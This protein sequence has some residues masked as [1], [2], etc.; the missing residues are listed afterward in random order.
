MM[1]VSPMARSNAMFSLLQYA[2]AERA[3]DPA[4][5]KKVATVRTPPLP[6]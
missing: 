1:K 6:D 4:E 3:T 2:E 5:H